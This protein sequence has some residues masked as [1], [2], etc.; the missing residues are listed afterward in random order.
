MDTSFASS[1]RAR[2]AARARIRHLANSTHT[3]DRVLLEIDTQ[4]LIE[5]PRSCELRE[6]VRLLDGD[7]RLKAMYATIQAAISAAIAGDEVVIAPG[8]YAEDLHINSR[9]TLTRAKEG[10][11]SEPAAG[12]AV[13]VGHVIVAASAVELAID[14]VAIEGGLTMQSVA[15][16]TAAI[17]L[18][19]SGI[20]GS[21]VSCAR[22]SWL[23][24]VRD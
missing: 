5:H 22:L 4:G 20:Q 8:V 11:G 16:T 13:V 12:K 3:P 14:G 1:A 9:V 7:G 10:S 19:S 18:R 17:T 2:A 24:H 21:G 6:A 15:G 23:P